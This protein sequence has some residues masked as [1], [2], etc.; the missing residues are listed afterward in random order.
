VR[1]L[2]QPEEWRNLYVFNFKWEGWHPM[3]VYLVVVDDTEEAEIALRFAARR[4][5]KTGGGV[6]ILTISEPEEF[7]AWGAV[8]ATIQAEAEERAQDVANRALDMLGDEKGVLPRIV[9]KHGEP[10]AMIMEA[11][12]DNPDVA[13]LVL[14]AAKD[15]VPGPLVAHFAGPEAGNLPVPL[16]VI[17]GSLSR[18]ALDRLS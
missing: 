10:V 1:D 17:P 16:M 14:G 18:E 9:V 4:A 5:A 8:Q 7:V 3:R 12:A 13:A 2:R 15:G 6:E 11:I